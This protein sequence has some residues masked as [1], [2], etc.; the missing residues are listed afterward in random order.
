MDM[1]AP[2]ACPIDTLLRQMYQK[3]YKRYENELVKIRRLAPMR[4]RQIKICCQV[5]IALRHQS[6]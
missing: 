4:Q 6:L 2:F 1:D 3:L 5:S